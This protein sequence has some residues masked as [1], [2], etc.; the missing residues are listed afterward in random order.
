MAD[1]IHKIPTCVA[2]VDCNNFFASCERAKQPEYDNVPVVILSSNDACIIARSEEA[3]DLGISMGMPLFQARS[4][5]A[6]H[7]V[8]MFSLNYALYTETSARIMLLLKE[9]VP[10][11]ETYSIDEAFLDLSG[12][13]RF[14]D[15]D[16]FLQDLRKRI[17]DEL[18][19]PVS[20]G[21]APTKALAKQANRI[22]KKKKTTYV[23]FMMT[24]E[25]QKA[26][27][28]KTRVE[29]VW[30]IGRRNAKKL[31]AVGIFS[32]WELRNMNPNVIKKI[33]GGVVEMRLLRELRGDS[34]LMIEERVEPKRHILSSRSFGR[35]ITTLEDIKGAF[36]FLLSLAIRKLHREK[37]SVT[38]IHVQYQ[39]ARNDDDRPQSCNRTV[40]LPVATDFPPEILRQTM[41]AVE[42]AFVTGCKYA[43]GA[44]TFSGLEPTDG[45]QGSLFGSPMNTKQRK[46]TDLVNEL[47]KDK[48]GKKMVD[49]AA[50]K[51]TEEET[52]WMPKSELLSD[53]TT[54][55]T[56][57]EMD[58]A[59]PWW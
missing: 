6:Q 13:E 59:K 42:E 10:N 14:F 12:M 38:Y 20:F 52:E 45:I 50:F 33:G 41:I 48:G 46:V 19:I 34:S 39:T 57:E 56:D 24:Y 31:N 40:H 28:E 23:E 15:L 26:A 9:A 37:Q 36:T 35:K 51:Q 30:G 44:V 21:V 16:K 17:W 7:N 3:K 22:A 43:R 29:N 58:V 49:W 5:I 32:G 8:K 2:L 4:I 53:H 54:T 25:S 55:I 18:R 27:L 11:A 47:N 1:I